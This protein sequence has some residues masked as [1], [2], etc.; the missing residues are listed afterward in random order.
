MGKRIDL[1]VFTV[2]KQDGTLR[3]GNGLRGRYQADLGRTGRNGIAADIGCLGRFQLGNVQFKC[4]Q[5]LFIDRKHI[6]PG[7]KVAIVAT[8]GNTALSR[9]HGIG[10]Q[11]GLCRD[12]SQFA[13]V[14]QTYLQQWNGS[15]QIFHI[16]TP[17]VVE[18]LLSRQHLGT[19][20]TG[21][22]VVAAHVVLQTEE[23][24]TMTGD[25]IDCRNSCQR[26]LTVSNTL[27]HD[28]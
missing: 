25:A 4:L 8:H 15:L 24:M 27:V 2:L 21:K 10:I 13:P 5:L 1:R 20:R 12:S 7:L 3:K 28:V 9:L 6:R 18:H 26:F 11:I 17:F 19:E 22:Q 14:F 16:L 23:F